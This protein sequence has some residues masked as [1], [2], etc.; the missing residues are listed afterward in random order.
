MLIFSSVGFGAAVAGCWTTQ[1]T[2][3][4][5]QESACQ[6]ISNLIRI[7]WS[8]YLLISLR[9]RIAIPGTEHVLLILVA[10]THG[11]ICRRLLLTGRQM[12]GSW[13]SAQRICA[14]VS[15]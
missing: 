7:S 9:L 5:F 14:E 13:C 8:R 10:S 4:T 12:G 15:C 6:E 2:V 11:Q 3:F 1:E